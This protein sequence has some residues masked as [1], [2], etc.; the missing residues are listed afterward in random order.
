[1]FLQAVEL[2]DVILGGAVEEIIPLAGGG[3]VEDAAR[4]LSAGQRTVVAR[5]GAQGALAVTPEGEIIHAPAFP[6]QVVDTVGAGDAF[7]GGFI[8]AR[9]A[10]LDIEEA[11]RWG[12]AVAALKI[13][14][15]G[16]RG[17][18]GLAEVQALAGQD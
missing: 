12:N 9:L 17:L 13:G 14:R 15:H 16:A 2:S 1:L 6:T 18:P 11:L 3:S 7:D 10:G 4:A 5:L 8:A